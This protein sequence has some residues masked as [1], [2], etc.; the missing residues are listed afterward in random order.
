MGGA[1][2]RTCVYGR[3]GNSPCGVWS[4][5]PSLSRRAPNARIREERKL[6]LRRL[7][8]RALPK[9]PLHGALNLSGAHHQRHGDE[10]L[11]R[12]VEGLDCLRR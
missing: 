4:T 2:P 5:G 7:E 11:P 9:P 3:R 1:G 12:R 6:P 10:N 8:R